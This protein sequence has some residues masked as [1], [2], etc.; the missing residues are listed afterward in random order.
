MVKMVMNEF[1]SEDYRPFYSYLLYIVR[2]VRIS[3]PIVK[4]AA[5]IIGRYGI[6]EGLTKDSAKFLEMVE[7]LENED[8]IPWMKKNG[9]I[10]IPTDSPGTVFGPSISIPLARMYLKLAIANAMKLDQSAEEQCLAV[11]DLL[12]EEPLRSDESLLEYCSTVEAFKQAGLGMAVK[13]KIMHEKGVKA[14]EK[15]EKIYREVS[16]SNPIFEM[17][18]STDNIVISSESFAPLGLRFLAPYHNDY[19]VDK[20]LCPHC[21]ATLKESKRLAEEGKNYVCKECSYKIK[22]SYFEKFKK[23]RKM[24]DSAKSKEQK[25]RIFREF[26]GL[27]VSRK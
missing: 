9:V 21:F 20:R 1:G 2:T 27:P 26:V 3:R 10:E 23:A 17:R 11:K 15:A 6:V 12:D 16:D 18:Q 13:D 4:K 5:G 7:K 14:C 24:Y 25:N 22:K 8:I 19:T